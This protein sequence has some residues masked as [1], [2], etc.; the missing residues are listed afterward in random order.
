MVQEPKP[1]IR[2][3]EI[4][5]AVCRLLHDGPA[6]A[7]PETKCHLTC[8]AMGKT[9]RQANKEAEP[10]PSSIIGI[11]QK[12]DLENRWFPAVDWLTATAICERS[13]TTKH[14]PGLASMLRTWRAPVC[15]LRTLQ[16][17][18]REKV[19]SRRFLHHQLLGVSK[20]SGSFAR[21]SWPCPRRLTFPARRERADAVELAGDAGHTS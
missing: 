2:I 11:K 15:P 7:A 13:Q 4:M 10:A 16:G 3:F 12:A 17:P 20:Q 9:Y 14:A 18:S 21:A 6:M 1:A 19:L 5:L 8:T